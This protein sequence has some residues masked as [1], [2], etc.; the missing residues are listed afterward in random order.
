MGATGADPSVAPVGHTRSRWQQLD[1]VLRQGR[2]LA[3]VTAA[4]AGFAAAA[5]AGSII[6]AAAAGIL[7]AFTGNGNGLRSILAAFTAAAAFAAVFTAAVAFAVADVAPLSLTIRST[8][9]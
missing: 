3:A 7:A 1:S 4:A 8:I 5:A 6:A 9:S 2:G